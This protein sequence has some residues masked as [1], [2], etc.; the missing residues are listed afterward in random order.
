MQRALLQQAMQECVA[1][2]KPNVLQPSHREPDA[3]SIQAQVAQLQG[4]P[5]Q[6]HNKTPYPFLHLPLPLKDSVVGVLQVWLQ[7]YVTPQNCAEFAQFLSSLAA[8]VEQHLQSRRLGSLVLETQRLQHLLKF[9]TDLA[10]S[11]D[12]LEVSRLAAN[13]G[14]DLVSCER[15]SVLWRDGARWRVVSISEIQPRFGDHLDRLTEPH[16][17]YLF[18]L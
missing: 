4:T 7:P 5:A 3:S 13:Y 16:H 15:C 18:G 10:G 2:K 14:R 9:T 8:Y 1:T 17:Q 12:V 11:L 6:P